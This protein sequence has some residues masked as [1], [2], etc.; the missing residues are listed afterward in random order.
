M[1]VETTYENALARKY[2][3]PIAI[4]VVLDPQG[5]PNPITLGWVMNTSQDPP[6]VAISIGRT[7]HSLEALRR[8]REFVL[9]FPSAAMAA[10]A[11]FFGSR[12]GRDLDKLA[13]R[14]TRTQ[15]ARVVNSVLLADAVANFECRVVAELETGD[16]VLFVGQV[17]A[18]HA[19][20]DPAV[21]RIYSLGNEGIGPVRPD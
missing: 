4:A 19:H 13:A 17:V 1:Q 21:R 11:R 14:G 20:R 16:H 18:A 6:Q 9:S 3:E 2:P 5:K 15:A 10:D 7:R 8:A 12:S